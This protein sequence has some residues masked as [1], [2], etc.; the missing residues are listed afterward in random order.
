MLKAV[1]FD[2]DGVL[3]DSE[4]LHGK[5]LVLAMKQLGIDIS[6]TYCYTFVGTTNFHTMSTIIKDYNLNYTVEEVL[7]LYE[8]HKE[9]LL[10]TEG[11]IPIPYTKELIQSLKKEGILLAIA[12]SSSLETISYITN[13]FGIYAYFDKIISGTT[14]KRSKPAPDIYIKAAEELGVSTD[15]CLVIED[16]TVGVAAGKAAGMPVVGFYNPNSGNQDL[17]KADI[18][19]EGFEEIDLTFLQQVHERYHNIP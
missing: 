11:Y 15:E 16:A 4:L 19:M 9:N 7:N 1:L 14:L 8:E 6:L 18:I 2:M 17:S 12:S 5:A 3:V 10:K 13:T